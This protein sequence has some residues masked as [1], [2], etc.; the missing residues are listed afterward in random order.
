MF[1]SI[2]LTAGRRIGQLPGAMWAASMAGRAL[3]A[4]DAAMQQVRHVVCEPLTPSGIARIATNV[5]LHR[6]S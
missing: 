5:R 2:R 4:W 1:E 3:R 6:L